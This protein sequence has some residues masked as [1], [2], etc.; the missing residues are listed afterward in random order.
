MM[1][2][3]LSSPDI[4]EEDIAAVTSVLRT[5][6]LSIGPMQESFEKEFARYVGCRHAV[7]VSSGTAGLHLSL[8]AIGIAP[9]DEVI[10]PS[11]TFIAAANAVRYVG[12]KPVF[13][14]I[15]AGTLNMDPARVE[16]AVTSRTRALMVVHTFGVPANLTRLLAVA[17][18]HS[19]RVIEDA[20]EAIGAE[21][22]GRKVGTFG[23]AGVFGFYPNKQITT[24][25]GG[26]VVTNDPAIAAA[27]QA[28]RNHGRTGSGDWL[29]H[30]L[31]GYNY[32][33]SEMNCAL[34]LAQLR[35]IDTILAARSSRAALYDC[36]LRGKGGL[37]LPALS[38]PDGLVSWFT[39][40]VRLS[41][42]STAEQ[43]DAVASKLHDQGIACGR[44]FAPIHW[45][46]AYAAEGFVEL[47]LEV[48]ESTAGRTLALPF[49]NRIS[50][51]QIA[52][53]SIRL[54]EAIDAAGAMS[55][56]H[57]AT[58]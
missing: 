50:E 30:S 53:V 41:E 7:A 40:V 36:Q 28:L 49:F 42:G 57:T 2:I 47:V 54:L 45:Q 21:H 34:G 16:A 23:D 44:Y 5:P 24:G 3:P 6:Q 58:D 14:D 51:D 35:R 25:E 1:R 17:A 39:Y 26:M 56:S 33:L 52:E 4:D 29:E 19:L 22:Q 10:V 27:V 15:E 43:R 18:R 48:T 37:A 11:F 8:L 12:A 32:R 9:G 38:V 20:C 31:L 46:G 55:G 13:V